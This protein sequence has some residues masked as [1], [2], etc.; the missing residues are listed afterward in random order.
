I[1]LVLAASASAAEPAKLVARLG[2]PSPAVRDKALEALVALGEEA[3]PALQAA[4]KHADPEVR[5]RAG[6]ALHRIRWRLSPKLLAG[7]GDL[8]GRY[9]ERPASEREMICRDLALGGLADAVPTLKQI[10]TT[11]PSQAVRQAAAR[12]LVLLGDEG[13]QALLDA[14]VQLKGL[15]RYTVSVRI[16]LGN[17]YLERA[18]YDKAL[19]QY[20]K[21]LELEPENSVAHYNIACTYSEMKEIDNALDALETAVECG[22]EDVEWM[23][24]DE[25]LDNLRDQPRYQAIVR[26]LR[27][28]HRED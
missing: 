20:R 26:A 22:Y 18:E 27:E 17:S 12:A 7:I 14:G 10:L 1:A 13:V 15:E 9:E 8:M 25:D 19:A 2:D 24:K 28:K 5:W 4:Q 16:H 3:K 23:E 6:V 21:A 11:D